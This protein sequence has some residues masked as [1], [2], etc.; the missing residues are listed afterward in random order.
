MVSP[1]DLVG[2]AIALLEPL[3]E[4]KR[5]R[6]ILQTDCDARFDLDPMLIRQAV[7][8]V[9]HNAVKYSPPDSEI[10]VQVLRADD[11]QIHIV[12][13]DSGP[14]IAPEHTAR[15]FDRFYRGDQ[16]R[17]RDH[18]GFGLGLAIA[19]WAVRAHGGSVTVE[20]EPGKGS[21]FSI[22]LPLC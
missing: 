18:G 5:Q 4:E 6:L 11:G 1:A 16:S 9:L 22:K 17:G 13:T 15:I 12:V 20:S 8:N 3:T 7:I 10:S 2:Q 19:K 14:G 21:T